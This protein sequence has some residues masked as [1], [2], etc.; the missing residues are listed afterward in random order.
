MNV[1]TLTVSGG[2]TKIKTGAWKAKNKERKNG[3]IY[4]QVTAV[5]PARFDVWQRRSPGPPGQNVMMG[6]A[7]CRDCSATATQTFTCSQGMNCIFMITVQK[8]E[9]TQNNLFIL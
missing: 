9:P 8:H 1:S 3:K 7:C 4:L 6:K 5:F 2:N